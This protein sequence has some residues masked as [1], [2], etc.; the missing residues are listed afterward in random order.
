MAGAERRYRLNRESCGTTEPTFKRRRLISPRE[1]VHVPA[2]TQ[3]DSRTGQV[4]F[5]PQM[6]EDKSVTMGRVKGDTLLD[7]GTLRLELHWENI[8]HLAFLGGDC[9]DCQKGG[10]HK[11]KC[12][13]AEMAPCAD[14]AKEGWTQ[15]RTKGTISIWHTDGHVRKPL[16]HCPVQTCLSD[17]F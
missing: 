6:E 2:S 5:N 14:P 4:C 10:C 12:I 15:V 9:V 7:T 3:S 8:P 17:R 1:D 11:E 16:H 13:V